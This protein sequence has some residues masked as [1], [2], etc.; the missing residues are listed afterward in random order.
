MSKKY[1][2]VLIVGLLIL[3]V[4]CFFRF[5][6]NADYWLVDIFSHFPVQYAFLALII[7][8]ICLWKKCVALAVL[9]GFLCALNIGAIAAID[10]GETIHAARYAQTPVNVFSA[11]LHL[12]N[13]DLSKLKKELQVID[14]DILLLLEV[15]PVHF[16]QLQSV[17]QAY[18]Y[19]VEKGSFGG[20][21]IGFVFLSKMP[22]L[23]NHVTQLSQV[24][25]FILEAT[26]E[27]N[28]KPVIFYGVHSQRPDSRNYLERKNQLL[29]LARHIKEQSL[30]VIVAGD[31]NT[32]PYSPIFRAFINIT[33]LTDSR[34]GFGWQPSWP[35]YFPPLW[36]PIDHVLVTPDIQVRKRTTGSFI[37]SDHY[38]VIAELNLG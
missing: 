38:P 9:A 34:E 31:F 8:S 10:V 30:P 2:K 3:Y 19:H 16:K 24:C 13:E 15:T 20:P 14:P 4:P 5:F 17:I 12:H 33:G 25:N 11:N 36:I 28:Q 21:E 23:N 26:I 27:I 7:F 29:Q 32:T 6:D 18:P 22:V 35:T 1:K 37:G